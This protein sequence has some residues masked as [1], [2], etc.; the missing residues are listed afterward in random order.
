MEE[1]DIG[2]GLKARIERCIKEGDS[3]GVAAFSLAYKRYTIARA[4]Q[5]DEKR[6]EFPKW[7]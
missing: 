6:K 4:I 5:A 1:Y 7:T 2:K 3:E